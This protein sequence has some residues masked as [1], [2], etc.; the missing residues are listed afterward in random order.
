LK[1]VLF[2]RQQDNASTTEKLVYKIR[3]KKMMVAMEGGLKKS[4]SGS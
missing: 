4:T 2:G 1:R 3:V